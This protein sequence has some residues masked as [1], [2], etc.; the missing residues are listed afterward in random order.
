MAL[1]FKPSNKS[2]ETM[3]QQRMKQLNTALH[4]LAAEVEALQAKALPL[5]EEVENFE[6][7]N[8]CPGTKMPMGE[9]FMTL[10]RLITKV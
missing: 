7:E 5:V 1:P 8:E 4:N 2:E 6:I 3:N 9:N 10:Q